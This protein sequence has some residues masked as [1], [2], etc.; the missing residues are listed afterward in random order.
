MLPVCFFPICHADLTGKGTN[1]K[2][3]NEMLFSHFG[4]NYNNISQQFRK[5]S[6]L[7]R[8]E[9]DPEISLIT[10]HLNDQNETSIGNVLGM[11]GRHVKTYDGL[12]GAVVVTHEDII[13]GS[14]WVQR[15]WLLAW[16]IL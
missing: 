16:Y 12:T 1:S 10:A 15:P 4:I 11:N 13:L 5:G 7:V 6:V 8:R 14:F 2:D 9:P 3:K